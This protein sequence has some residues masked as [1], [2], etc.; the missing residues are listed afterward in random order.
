ML[1]PTEIRII[2]TVPLSQ[3]AGILYYYS[4]VRPNAWF[5]ALFDAYLLLSQY[6]FQIPM[7]PSLLKR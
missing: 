1:I 2:C 3:I 6:K 4:Y 7:F 5:L